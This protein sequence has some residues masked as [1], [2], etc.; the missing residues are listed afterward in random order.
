MAKTIG[1]RYT[2]DGRAGRGLD[3]FPSVS[4]QRRRRQSRPSRSPVSPSPTSGEQP[5][6]AGSNSL[7]GQFLDQLAENKASPP[8]ILTPERGRFSRAVAQTSSAGVADNRRGR[9]ARCHPAS[10]SS[11]MWPPTRVESRSPSTTRKRSSRSMAKR[12]ASSRWAQPI[13]LRAGTHDMEVKWGDGQFQTRR[14][15]VRRGENES[16]NVEYEP[17]SKN[18][19]T[20]SREKPPEDASEARSWSGF[21]SSAEGNHK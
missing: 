6:P 11:S 17:T 14:F 18:G 10:A 5:Q 7:V 1:D 3:G 19:E 12:S 2:I 20:A 16:L 9:R 8:S 21:D 13:T 4:R 15:V